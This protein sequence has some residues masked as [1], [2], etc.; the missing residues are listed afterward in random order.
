MKMSSHFRRAAAVV[1]CVL[2]STNVR[3]VY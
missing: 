3:N 2:P 1:E